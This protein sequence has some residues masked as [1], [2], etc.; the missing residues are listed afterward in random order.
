MRLFRPRQP[1]RIRAG[2][3]LARLLRD[4]KANTLVIM[5]I[6]L[7]PISGLA[8]S[9]VDMAR[10]YVV[11]S[12]LQQACDAGVLAGRKY[13]TVG[14]GALD[15]TATA[16][17]TEFFRNNMEEGWLQTGRASFTPTKT[18]DNQVAGTA[19]VLVPMTVMKMFAAPDRTIN[20]SCQAR[21]DVADT[22]IVFVL[23]TTGSM[24]CP[25][26]MTNTN[27]SSYVSSLGQTA[28][29]RP[30]SDPDAMPGYLGSSSYYV[31]E[32]N[33]GSGSR[34]KA[35]RQAVKD[36]YATMDGSKDRNTRVRYG[37]VTYTSTVNAGKAIFDASPS[38]L[39]GANAGETVDYETRHPTADYWKRDNS[40]GVNGKAKAACNAVYSRNP[41]TALTYNA[42]GEAT[43]VYDVWRSDSKCYTVNATFGPVWTYEQWPLDVSQFI[44]GGVTT[45]PTRFNNATTRWDGCIEERATQAGTTN[46]TSA[47]Y[48][49]DPDLIPTSDAR[50]R[51]RPMWP[52][53]TWARNWSMNNNR[54]TSTAAI[55]TNGDINAPLT[56]DD[57]AEFVKSGF[58]SC[59]KPIHRL[60]EMSEDEVAA[61]VDASDFR[62]LGGT[63]H[64]TGMIW[65]VRM[66]SMKG[67]FAAD[68]TGRQGQGTP[69]KVIVF[70]TDGDMAPNDSLYGLYGVEYLD[71]RVSG[72]SGT[73]KDYHNARFIYECNK[74]RT[75]GVDVWT[76][77]IGLASTAEL[78]S[79][80]RTDAQAL[81]TTSGSGLST[82]FQT[83]AKQVAMLRLQQ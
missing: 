79:C 5:A 72:G 35:L 34:I 58:Y 83:I 54:F 25:P 57:G 26:E 18:S 47:S 33:G 59:G 1:H 11:K 80:A 77:A 22:D 64:D 13:M 32:A 56:M 6:A 49:L 51:W 12:R 50:T 20:V 61:Y 9:A 38:Y 45:D 15:A 23:D 46:F 36:F 69:K 75:M 76:V 63:Y 52:R 55:T 68:N 29:T 67:I 81:S 66:L 16:R 28:Y 82:A 19:S 21:Y 17:A 78:K 73:L 60:S 53:V 39:M 71:K 14:P 37:F 2:S 65:G 41:S 4:R 3:F 27:C 74:A 8:G 40:A 24:A 30:T 43:V 42:A 70:L 44:R 7:I 48:D 31:N 10:L 62:A